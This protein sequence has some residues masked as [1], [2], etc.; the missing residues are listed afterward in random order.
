LLE[1]S[2]SPLIPLIP[3]IPIAAGVVVLPLTGQF[4]AARAT[5]V[6]EVALA[7]SPRIRPASSSSTSPEFRTPTRSSPGRCAAPDAQ[8]AGSVCSSPAPS[9]SSV[10]GS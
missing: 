6:L 3:L 5:G 8:F 7:G 10:R 9:A 4:D 1:R 2:S